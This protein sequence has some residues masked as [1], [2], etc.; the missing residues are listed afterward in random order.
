MKEWYALNGE[1]VKAEKRQQR[2]DDPEQWRQRDQERLLRDGDRIR[3]N[4]RARYTKDPARKKANVRRYVQKFPDTIRERQRQYRQQNADALRD[5]RRQWRH[6]NPDRYQSY[7]ARRRAAKRQAPRNDLSFEQWTEIKEHYGHRCVYCGK[8]FTRLTQDHII[9]L[10]RGGE[11]TASN[12]VPACRRCN[13]AKNDGAPLVPVQPLLLT[14]A[15]PRK[16]RRKDD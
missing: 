7:Q 4:S 3:A 2:L 1:R 14:V 15:P 5:Y 10:V 13:S 8:K 9:P 6:T 12:I 11:H 16:K